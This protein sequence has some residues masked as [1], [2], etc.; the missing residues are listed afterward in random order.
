MLKRIVKVDLFAYVPEEKV[1]KHKGLCTAAVSILVILAFVAYTINRLVQFI[2]DPS[3]GYSLQYTDVEDDYSIKISNFAFAIASEKPIHDVSHLVSITAVYDTSRNGT[4]PL[5]LKQKSCGKMAGLPSYV[6][7]INFICF[8]PYVVIPGTPENQIKY[9][10]FMTFMINV[11]DCATFLSSL[12]ISLFLVI[13][14]EFEVDLRNRAFINKTGSFVLEQVRLQPPL[15]SYY[16]VSYQRQDFVMSPD[17]L[18]KWKNEN[19]SRLSITKFI[20]SYGTQAGCTD[21][22]TILS[23]ITLA[24]DPQ[25]RLTYINYESIITMF[26]QVGSFWTTSVL[27]L[28]AFLIRI[29]KRRY[30]KFKKSRTMDE[31]RGDNNIVLDHNVPFNAQVTLSINQKNNEELKEQSEVFREGIDSPNE[32]PEFIKDLLSNSNSNSN[33]KSALQ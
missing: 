28:G 12:P 10:K 8:D 17:Y 1:E 31:P 11:T 25:I 5:V 33:S 9:Q 19:R 4:A 32:Q 27:V 22:E 26:S 30:D 21:G 18:I 16:G 15:I 6:D 2:K 20:N 23:I 13:P 14:D 3:V 29:N 7:K 24:M